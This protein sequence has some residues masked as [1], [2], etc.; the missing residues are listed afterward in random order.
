VV[1]RCEKLGNRLGGR[2]WDRQGRLVGCEFGVDVFVVDIATAGVDA[3]ARATYLGLGGGEFDRGRIWL[4][5]V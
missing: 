4:V 1:A 5:P 3:A 2:L